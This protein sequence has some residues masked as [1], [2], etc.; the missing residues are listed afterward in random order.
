MNS[1]GAARGAF[2]RRLF[3]SRNEPRCIFASRRLAVDGSTRARRRSVEVRKFNSP[4][5][6]KAVVADARLLRRPALFAAEG[7][8]E[9]A[10]PVEARWCPTA[11]DRKTQAGLARRTRWVR[12]HL[13]ID[14]ARD[15]TPTAR[16]QP[17]TASRA[18]A[19]FG[20]RRRPENV[21]GADRR[22]GCQTSPIRTRTPPRRH[23]R[24]SRAR[25]D[26]ADGAPSPGRAVPT[27][28]SVSPPHLS[29]LLA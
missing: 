2:R 27:R 19:H 16:D 17:P 11:G 20:R 26:S 21:G 25:V 7:G 1:V 18:F 3:F 5:A 6:R 12:A 24:R 29:A 8:C 13:P 23:P 15:G 9:W 10:A 14:A 4:R 22:Q 28:R